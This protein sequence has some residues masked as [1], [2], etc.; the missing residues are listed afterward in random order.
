MN[1]AAVAVFKTDFDLAAFFS[2]VSP[3]QLIAA[4][5]ELHD[6]QT[7]SEAMDS[8]EVGEFSLTQY[9]GLDDSYT[10]GTDILA[11]V[12]MSYTETGQSQTSSVFFEMT[13]VLSN[14]GEPVEVPIPE[15]AFVFPLAM[16]MQMGS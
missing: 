11:D 1:G 6:P 15:D 5:G 3:E 9:I 12:S 7:L 16:L 10:H 14:F 4:S 8:I 2:L 13:A